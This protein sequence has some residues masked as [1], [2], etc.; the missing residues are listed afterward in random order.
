MRE[1]FG[2]SKDTAGGATITACLALTALLLITV[3]LVQ[4]AAAICTRHQAQ[5]AADL[6]ALGAAAA[7]NGGTGAACDRAESLARSMR[8]RVRECAVLEWDVTVTV[9]GSVSSGVLVGRSVSAVARAGPVA[10]GNQS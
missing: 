6:A 4:T 3:I 5:S 1:S 10:S 9:E 8:M 7:L 2:R